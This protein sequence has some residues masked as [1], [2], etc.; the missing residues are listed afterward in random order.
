MLAFRPDFVI[1]CQDS[2]ASF[3]GNGQPGGTGAKKG[4]GRIPNRW[5]SSLRTDSLARKGRPLPRMPLRA[6]EPVRRL[7]KFNKY[8]S[9]ANRYHGGVI[10]KTNIS[11][12]S[13]GERLF[14]FPFPFSLSISFP[15]PLA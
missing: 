5:S 6:R 13:E 8:T 10:T 4:D 3:A 15:V 7:L 9:C 11:E 2:V 14:S 12:R 1:K